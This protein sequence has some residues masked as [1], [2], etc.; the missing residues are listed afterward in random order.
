MDFCSV[1]THLPG[2][3][4]AKLNPLMD[5]GFNYY[6]VYTIGMDRPCVYT[7]TDG[8]VQSRTAIQTGPP[9]AGVC[10]S[11]YP[12][13]TGGTLWLSSGHIWDTTKSQLKYSS[14]KKARSTQHTPFR[15]V[16]MVR[17]CIDKRGFT[18]MVLMDLPKAYDCL[19]HDLLIA[20]L[21]AYGFGI[22]SLKLVY[23]YLTDRK[24]RAKIG[25]SFSTW[26]SLSKGVPQGSV[27]GTLLLNIF[28]ISFM[29]L[30]TLKFEIFL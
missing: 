21:D 11:V 4:P 27:L 6:P 18:I 2:L 29:L 12:G 24:Q 20:K 1:N 22:D 10:N 13:A 30:N 23:S 25:T 28:M 17:R 16:E 15:V 9:R 3:K 5:L 7:E 8:T 19:P 26:K 14:F